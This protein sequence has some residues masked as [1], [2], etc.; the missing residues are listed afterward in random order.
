MNYMMFHNSLL[1]CRMR[2]FHRFVTV[3]F[4][5]WSPFLLFSFSLLP[6]SFF[7]FSFFHTFFIFPIFPFA[8]VQLFM[9]FIFSFFTF[10]TVFHFSKFSLGPVP[11]LSQENKTNKHK[12][13]FG[14]N[15]KNRKKQ[16]NQR[17]SRKPDK[18][19]NIRKQ[20]K[21]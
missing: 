16:E 20:K 21:T 11:F 9:L 13:F 6:G 10:D 4:L 14:K 1:L 17:K 5:E 8:I 2:C 19:T 12:R 3:F 7:P 18:G 15:K